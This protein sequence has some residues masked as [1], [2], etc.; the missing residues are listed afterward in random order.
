M[1]GPL[2][3]D[4]DAASFPEIGTDRPQSARIYNYWLGGKDY[5]PSTA[6]WGS[7]SAPSFQGSPRWLAANARSSPGR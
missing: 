6:R 4:S 3:S 7:R 1:S 2:P 5:S